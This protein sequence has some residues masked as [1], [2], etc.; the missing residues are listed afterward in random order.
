M[1]LWKAVWNHKKCSYLTLPY[2]FSWQLLCHRFFVP[3]CWHQSC[4]CGYKLW[5]I[6]WHLLLDGPFLNRMLHPQHKG[7]MCLARPPIP[8]CRILRHFRQNG[9]IY[10]W[11]NIWNKWNVFET[12]MVDS[13]P[14][15]HCSCLLV[16]CTE[17]SREW[18]LIL[19]TNHDSYFFIYWEAR[20]FHD[21][22]LVRHILL[23]IFKGILLSLTMAWNCSVWINYLTYQYRKCPWHSTEHG[24]P[25]PWFCFFGP[26]VQTWPSAWL[27][28]WASTPPGERKENRKLALKE[29]FKVIALFAGMLSFT[30][31]VVIVPSLFGCLK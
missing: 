29:P 15:Q 1:F 28:Y 25:N 14:D 18:R 27:H 13:G 7:S 11:L 4:T 21:E 17:Y 26:S 23:A 8:S 30:K 2:E 16:L 20:F 22:F 19:K 6:V 31:P 12:R 5:W 9:V 10:Y 24:G 3:V